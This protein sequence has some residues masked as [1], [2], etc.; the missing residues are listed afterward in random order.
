MK[1]TINSVKSTIRWAAVMVGAAML[2]AGLQS[3]TAQSI[4]CKFVSG[5]LGGIDNTE[6]DSMLSTDLAGAPPYAQ[7]NWNNLSLANSGGSYTLTDGFG[8]PQTLILQWSSGGSTSEGT[9]SSLGTPDG[10]LFDVGLSYGSRAAPTPLGNSCANSPGNDQPLVYV[11]GL[12]A[13]ATSIGA[14]GYNVVLYTSGNNWWET[15]EG[16]VESVSGDPLAN[17]MVEGAN[18]VIPLYEQDNANFSGSYSPVTSANSGSPTGGANYMFFS[19]V[20]NNDAI[21]LRLEN[22]GQGLSGFQIIP[23]FPAKLA[24]IGGKF[25]TGNAGGIDNSQADSMLPTDQAGAPPYAQTNWNNLSSGSSSLYGLTDSTGAVQPVDVQWSSWA[26]TSQGTASGLGTPDGKLFDL[27]LSTWS[28]GTATPLGTSCGGS[29]GNNQPVVFLSGLNAWF[30]SFNAEGYAVILYTCGDTYYETVQGY[31]ESVSGSALD[32]N[33]VE[34]TSLLPPLFEGDSATFSGNYVPAMST[35]SSSATYGANYM[36]FN[37]LTNDAILLRLQTSGYGQGLDGFQ[38][39][40]ILP[41]P[42]TAGTPTFSPS[43]TVYAGVPVT[44][45]ETATGDPFH[46][47]LW[48]QWYSDNATGGPVTNVIL[49]ATS[50]TFGVTPTNNPTSYSIQY[51]VVV[52]NI[53]GA[54]TSGVV[55]LTVNTAVAPIVTQDT[56][57]GPGNGLTTAYAYAGGSISFSA[58]FD[59]TPGSYLWQSNSVNIPGATSTTLTLNNLPL[60]ASASYDVTDTNSIGGAATTPTPLTVLADLPAPTASAPYAYDVFTNQPVAYWR[61]AETIDN[62]ANSVQ[63]YDYSGNNNEATYG[64]AAAENQAGPQSPQFAGFEAANTGV[65]LQNN[66]NNSDLMAPSLSLKT[67]TV[68]ITAWINPSSNIGTYW[69]LFMWRG[70]NSD[71]A[72]FGFGG[73]SSSGMAE[74][75]YTWNSNSPG[76]YNYH[77]ALYPP[78]GQWSFVTLAITPTNSTIYLYYIDQNSG[79][80]N[81]F[82]AVQASTNLAEAFSG[83]TTTIGGDN[84]GAGRNF[85]GT[86]AEVAVFNKTLSEEQVQNLFLTA[87]GSP[88]LAPG[89]LASAYPATSVYS[90]Q[91]VR[92]N[93]S[94]TGTVPMTL[95]WQ[96]SPNGVAWANILGANSA[97]VLVN[98]LTV[99]T[100][101]YQLVASNPAGSASNSVAVAFDALPATP[102]GLWTVN[103]ELTNNVTAG[104]IGLGDYS[105]RGIL[106]SGSYWN[107]I[108]D[109]LGAYGGGSFFSV[110]DFQDDGATHS[111]VSCGIYS[112]GGMSS[113]GTPQPDSSDIG[114]LLYQYVICWYSPNEL[115]IKDLPNGTYNLCCYAC[116]G[117]YANAG[118]TFVAHDPQNGDQTQS[119]LNASPILP[120]QQNVN[121]VVFSN[122]H[123]SGGTL[124]VDVEPNSGGGSTEA[125]FNGAQ[126]Q[127]VSLDAVA[128]TNIVSGSNMTLTWPGT[129]TLQTSTNLLGPWIP[130]NAPSPVTVPVATT[131]SAQFYRVKVE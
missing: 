4:G 32:N 38:I 9:A 13:W 57:P 30:N 40:P 86:L 59:G 124:S 122:V 93:A 110:S 6:A 54:S 97:S 106:G 51:L 43:S 16:C 98:P 36:F 27:G 23:V 47:N 118:T 68:T 81:L 91:N 111:G 125:D 31:I 123:V 100:V 55:T 70:T 94:V 78:V 25:V 71:A 131:N 80:T 95:Q 117:S 102:A 108:S 48:F 45:T 65:G 84:N 44:L 7:T 37:A 12:N 120:L 33:M 18:V 1:K 114:N 72:G 2:A 39:V 17:T 42:P 69:G 87:I 79:A 46:T 89:V 109:T 88:G 128:L 22:G 67:N 49:S 129:G 29:S 8:N 14:V 74:L 3:V 21:L 10:K 104:G 103:F 62:T 82:K 26:T 53:F 112:C 77:S 64:S 92:L 127:L 19:T 35:S 41:T 105:G 52:T 66:V 99:G 85:N 75:G 107:A 60:S 11:G 24:S 116:N 15:Y 90:G 83:G 126:I 115:Q 63:A 101:Y 28:P 130:I 76:T 56:T 5:S 113:A 58:A 20:L 121:F 50:A 96:A 119:T 61:F 34:G 73:N